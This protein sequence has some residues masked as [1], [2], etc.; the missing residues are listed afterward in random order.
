MNRDEQVMAELV[1]EY[2]N[3]EPERQG[4][5]RN[6][7]KYIDRVAE[8]KMAISRKENDIAALKREL[9]KLPQ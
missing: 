4:N 1:R 3:G 8:M 5:E 9:S 6:Y 2:N 7:Q